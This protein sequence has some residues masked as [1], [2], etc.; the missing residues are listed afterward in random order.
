MLVTQDLSTNARN[1][2]NGENLFQISNK[3]EAQSNEGKEGPLASWRILQ[4]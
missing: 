1:N 4:I 3:L 2:K